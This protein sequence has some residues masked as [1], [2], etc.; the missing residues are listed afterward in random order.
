MILCC[1]SVYVLS[2]LL[3]KIL[4]SL[5]KFYEIQT[6]GWQR[7]I[8]HVVKRRTIRKWEL[9]TCGNFVNLRTEKYIVVKYIQRESSIKNIYIEYVIIC[10]VFRK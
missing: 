1:K 2:G 6:G 3:S 5:N 9:N 7:E 4:G 8:L 10:R